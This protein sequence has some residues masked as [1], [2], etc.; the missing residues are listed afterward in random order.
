[1]AG[2]AGVGG[3]FGGQL[4]SYEVDRIHKPRLTEGPTALHA[5]IAVCTERVRVA[6]PLR[7]MPRGS[8]L[9]DVVLGIL[10]ATPRDSGAVPPIH[11][12]A[13]SL[14]IHEVGEGALLGGEAKPW[15]QPGVADGLVSQFRTLAVL[16][17][18]QNFH[19][20]LSQ[21]SNKVLASYG[22]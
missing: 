17:R 8:V 10:G 16:V 5:S 21:N 3:G 11:L 9:V 19:P 4:K 6:V 15:V 22:S 12:T 2:A 14:P 20:I 7:A 13:T 18:R 1:M